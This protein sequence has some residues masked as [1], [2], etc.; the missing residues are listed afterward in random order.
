MKC[1]RTKN[2]DSGT[3]FVLQTLLV[4][5]GKSQHLNISTSPGYSVGILRIDYLVMCG[6]SNRPECLSRLVVRVCLLLALD[7]SPW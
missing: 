3:Y 1:S 2:V 4:E 5:P 7:G 6:S